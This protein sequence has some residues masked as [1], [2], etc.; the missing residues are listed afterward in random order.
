MNSKFP[1]IT[2]LGPTAVGKTIFSAH[3]ASAL[4]AEIISADSRQVFR[5]MDIGTGK[6]ITDYTIAG[7]VIPS[8]LID[9]ADPGTEYNVFQ[10]QRDFQAARDS[11]ISKGKIPLMC[12]GT[13]LYLESVLL[14]YNLVEVPENEVLRRQ[15]AELPDDE[16]INRISSYRPL[17]NTTDIL[18]HERLFRAIEIEEYKKKHEN[19]GIEIDFKNTPVIGIRFDR[20]TVRDRIT[21]RLRQRL[22]EGMIEE[23]QQ[24]LASGIS[25][26]RLMFYGLE[27]KYITLYLSGELSYEEMFTLLN[28]AIHQFAKRQ[29]TWFRRMENKGIQIF[30]LDGEDGLQVNLNKA[31]DYLRLK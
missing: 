9:I 3:L 27:Y 13:G 2:V 15:L 30:W 21:F 4:N 8:H 22:N 11:I 20:K 29:V 31:F 19:Q 1:L 7:R 16:L 26:E 28:T 25:K 18:D 6:D 5:G 12:G 14:G 17:H 24:L 10:F 23:V